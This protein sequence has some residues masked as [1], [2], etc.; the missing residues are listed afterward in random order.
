MKIP[1]SDHWSQNLASFFP[2][3]IQFIGKYS[4]IHFFT[5]FY[6]FF[7]PVYDWREEEVRDVYE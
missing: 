1:I 7:F 4:F 5:L 2:K 6:D 3:A